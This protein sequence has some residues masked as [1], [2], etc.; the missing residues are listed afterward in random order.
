MSD[1]FPAQ[2]GILA[3]AR[4]E[5]GVDLNI[6]IGDLPEIVNEGMAAL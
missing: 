6:T 1:T 4:I 5:I 2:L 3:I